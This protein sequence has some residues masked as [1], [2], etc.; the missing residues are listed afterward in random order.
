[1][2][3]PAPTRPRV[4][5]RDRVG[6]VVLGATTLAGLATV[7]APDA[8]AHPRTGQN[9]DAAL[10]VIR[11]CESGARR[12]DGTAIPGTARNVPNSSGA[13]TA[14]GFYQI[15][16]GT[17]LGNGGGQF[18]P[19]ALQAT[20]EQQ[21]IVAKRIV[22][23]AG[24][25]FRDWDASAG[26]WRGAIAA[27][28]ASGSVR[29]DELPTPP[30]TTRTTA[31]PADRDCD[32]FPDQRAAQAE[33]ERDRSDP[34]RLDRDRDGQACERYF[35]GREAPRTAPAPPPPAPAADAPAVSLADQLIANG[36]AE[37]ARGVPYVYGG[38]N[39]RTGT[40]CSGFTQAIFRTVGVNIPRTTGQQATFG[41]AVSVAGERGLANAQRG[42]LLLFDTDGDGD[43]NHAGI[44]VGD[45]V[46]LDN[47]GN[48]K[49]PDASGADRDAT[50][51]R[52]WMSPV[53]IRR[54][55][56]AAP[57]A[58]P[59]PGPQMDAANTVTVRRG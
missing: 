32:D 15:T 9:I 1:M 45:G 27:A 28:L 23:N 35:A 51:R 52:V 10:K 24:G 46:M 26:C 19:T 7:V 38:T 17:W 49:A 22:A 34:N 50:E 57:A 55:L 21:T 5:T 40:D 20:F 58:A 36:R 25:T 42:D 30:A 56:P 59:A 18:A 11:D 12:A 44:Y 3:A 2:T 8:S 37:I 53:T 39:L 13:S 29:P 14:S 33:L 41:T 4:R 47:G 48:R 6:A 54:V 43:I 16:R 31:A